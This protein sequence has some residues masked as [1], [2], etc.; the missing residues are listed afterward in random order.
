MHDFVTNPK[1]LARTLHLLLLGDGRG[2]GRRG[3][4][5]R[6]V[7]LGVV[8]LEVTPEVRRVGVLLADQRLAEAAP[9]HASDYV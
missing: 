2:G 5:G 1:F 3:H 4:D 9:R 6:R 7:E 8:C